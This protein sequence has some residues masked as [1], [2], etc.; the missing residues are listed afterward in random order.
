M[1]NEGKGKERAYLQC[2]AS[3][4]IAYVTMAIIKVTELGIAYG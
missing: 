4:T 2:L 1:V 3:V